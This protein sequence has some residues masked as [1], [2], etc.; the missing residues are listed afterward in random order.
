MTPPHTVCDQ[1]YG[2][3]IAR[4][5]F[6]FSR[7]AWAHVS[8]TVVLNTPGVQDGNFVLEVDGRVAIN[9]TDVFYRD[10]PLERD[11]GPTPFCDPNS[12]PDDSLLGPLLGGL[13]GPGIE[14]ERDG[15]K[16][17]SPRVPLDSST[18]FVATVPYDTS[19][20]NAHS[21]PPVKPE[22][23]EDND[24]LC[25]DPEEGTTQETDDLVGFQGVFFRHVPSESL[26]DQSLTFSPALSTFF[27]GH[28]MKFATPKDQ[29]VWFKDF[30]LYINDP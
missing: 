17:L 18:G 19:D 2:L 3:S 13:I 25:V 6:S 28:H 23:L 20:A 27:G 30:A 15:A 5:S 8:Q 16:V 26:R 11:H 29:F 24:D 1:A 9:R 12:Q 10:K 4:G 7:G 22:S 14:S 21:D